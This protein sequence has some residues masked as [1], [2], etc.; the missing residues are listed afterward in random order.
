[1][2]KTKLCVPPVTLSA[3]SAYLRA[4]ALPAKQATFSEKRLLSVS[5][6]VL[7][8]FTKS[9]KITLVLNAPMTAS[10]VMVKETV[11]PATT[12]LITEF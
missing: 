8:G 1:M 10:H 3:L 11:W 6:P 4:T 2:T 7:Q 9:P 12:Q 5:T